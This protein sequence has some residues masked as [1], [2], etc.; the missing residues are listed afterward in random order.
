MK[1][2]KEIR[3]PENNWEV[4]LAG[5]TFSSTLD[6][7][8]R[9]DVNYQLLLGSDFK[10]GFMLDMRD[11]R[12]SDGDPVSFKSYFLHRSQMKYEFTKGMFN[13]RDGVDFWKRMIAALNMRVHTR[14]PR[15]MYNY[16]TEDKDFQTRHPRRPV[17]EWQYVGGRYRLFMDNSGIDGDYKSGIKNQFYIHLDIAKAFNLVIP[18]NGFPGADDKGYQ[19]S[20]LVMAEHFRDPMSSTAAI[21]GVH[22]LWPVIDGGQVGLRPEGTATKSWF[23]PLQAHANW[24]FYELDHSSQSPLYQKRPF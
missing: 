14:F 19:S 3:L 13:P 4:A 22:R 23:L 15:R 7:V 11:V 5:I 1:L 20:S 2:P 16:L 12:D 18:K 24:Y 10:C 9:N 6:T 21:G 17:F 8:I